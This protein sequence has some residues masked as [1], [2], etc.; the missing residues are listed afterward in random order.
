MG[1]EVGV[2]ARNNSSTLLKMLEKMLKSGFDKNTA[3]ELINSNLLLKSREESFATLD[4]SII[5]LHTGSVEFIKVGASPSFVKK[6]KSGTVDIIKSITLPVGILK[7]IDIDIYGK[8][9]ED[10]DILVMCSDGIIESN[11]IYQNKELWVKNLLEDI[12][13]NNVQKVA[14]LII[15]ESID[16]GYGIAK[17]DMTV[18][19]LKIIK[20]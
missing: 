6:K 17:D 13:T 8:D 9:L 18:M 3:V 20:K 2:I 15:T 7:D 5:D 16:N 11:A 10:E 1:W 12:D 14:D 19:V 4:A